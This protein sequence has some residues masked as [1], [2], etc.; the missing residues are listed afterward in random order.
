[1]R[2]IKKAWLGAVVLAF[3]VLSALILLRHSNFA[4]LNPQGPI[5]EQERHLFI[6]VTMLG[7]I[8][9]IPVFALLFGF[10]W[11]YREGNT[12]AKYSP[13][14]GGSRVAET[15]WWLIPLAIISIVSVL[16]WQSSH[17]LDPF[18]KLA[19][20]KK[21]LTVQVVALQWKWLFIYPDQH[22]A[23]VN[24][25]HF[26]E[27]T[28]VNFQITADAPMNSFWIPQLGGQI[29]AMAGMSTQLHLMADKT[30]NFTG[31]SAN[32]SGKGFSDMRFVATASTQN[33]FDNW[34]QQV[35]RSPNQ[36][37]SDTYETLAQPRKGYPATYYAS[38]QP[39]LYDDIIMKYMM[40]GMSHMHMEGME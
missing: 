25:L 20:D 19:S 5:G 10:A 1:M 29:Y 34:V 18:R 36:L 26:P 32:L 40:P 15:I 2:G 12:K 11:R 8:V 38:A 3:A 22:I 33:D 21:P 16:T 28:P 6:I 37:T 7:L 14:L 35:K 27:K 9:I 31:S 17:D 23:S 30:G 13:E 4:V 39:S 24:A